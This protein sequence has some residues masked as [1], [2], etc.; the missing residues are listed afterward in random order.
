MSAVTKIATSPQLDPENKRERLRWSPIIEEAARIVA[1]YKTGVTLR[2]LFYQLVSAQLISNNLSCYKTLSKLTAAA[3]R[4]GTF[5]PLIDRTR[6][7][8]QFLTFDSPRQARLWLQERYRR[9][10]TENQ[11]VSIYIG[12]EKAGIIEQLET[13]FGRPYGIP[14]LALGGY[15]SQTY[16]DDIV[17]DVR[18]RNRPAVLIYAGDFDPSGRDIL[19]DLQERCDVFEDVRQIALLPAQIIEYSL[20]EQ[21]GKATDSRS[22]GFVKEFSRLV[23]VELDALDP[24]VLFQLY[25]DAFLE[26]WNVFAYEQALNREEAER[27]KL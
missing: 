12:V 24:D 1:K 23:Q 16:A 7:I 2:Q 14:I 20:P 18:T 4:G 22:A 25:N 26:F 13:W 9:D 11:D 27:R 21:M 6:S 19:R 17:D 5:P 10:R 8:H 15:M 3:R